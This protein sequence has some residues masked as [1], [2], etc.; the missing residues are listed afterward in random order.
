MYLGDPFGFFI[1]T[2]SY[3][4]AQ[5]I[6]TSSLPNDS[7]RTLFKQI[8]IFFFW[9]TDCIFQLLALFLIYVRATSLECLLGISPSGRNPYGQLLNILQNLSK[10]LLSQR[11]VPLKIVLAYRPVACSTRSDSRERGG[12]RARFP[13]PFPL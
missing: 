9:H 11:C 7:M 5:T 6:E 13:P 3:L 4:R 12:L 2:T 10:S 1:L 8:K